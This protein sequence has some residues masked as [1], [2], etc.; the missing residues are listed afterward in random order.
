MYSTYTCTAAQE[1]GFAVVCAVSY[2]AQGSD[3]EPL[4]GRLYTFCI[5]ARIASAS[6]ANITTYMVFKNA[7]TYDWCA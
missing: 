3:F 4:K 6:P 1:P 7:R 5:F 2:V